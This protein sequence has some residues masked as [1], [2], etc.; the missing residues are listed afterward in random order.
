ML[1]AHEEKVRGSP[2]SIGVILWGSRMATRPIVVNSH[3]SDSH[4]A[5]LIK[6]LL[7]R[8]VSS[9]SRQ[10]C[11]TFNPSPQI[12]FHHFFCLPSISPNVTASLLSSTHPSFLFCLLLWWKFV[13]G[14]D[15]ALSVS[16]IWPLTLDGVKNRRIHAALCERQVRKESGVTQRPHCE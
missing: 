13:T 14:S 7:T 5:F 10:L 15:L 16:W 1:E 6:L 9:S 4:A 3:T 2:Q 8:N 11:F 12:T